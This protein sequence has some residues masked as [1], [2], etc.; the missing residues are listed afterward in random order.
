MPADPAAVERHYTRGG[1]VDTIRAA[2][3]QAGKDLDRL[4]VE[5]LAPLDHFHGRG[6]VATEQLAA[7]LK[8]TAVERVID[9]G[10]G[11][12]G[13]SRWLA[14]RFG[15]T[16]AGVDLTQEFVQVATMLTALTGL[17]ERVSYRQGT[18]LALPFPDASF[19][20]AW[21]QNASMNIADRAT[22]Y[23]EM[24]RVLKP[25]GRL[26]LQEVLQGPGGPPHFPSPWASEAGLSF[27]L[28]ETETRAALE[29]AGF[30]VLDWVDTT[31]AGGSSAATR[32]APAE[33]P[34]L[35]VH[36]LVGA[37]WREIYGNGTRNYREGRVRSMS[38][39]LRRG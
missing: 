6:L 30:A 10:S 11:I 8:P 16:V 7:Q 20:L 15:C 18:A 1:L 29:A 25:G 39:V 9:I 24:H 38:A 33:P 34:L 2:L 35:G 26:G 21:S 31:D 13:P 28:T 3:Q 23:R 22:L 37:R 4:T 19:D 5:D 32:A 12:G 27:L 14:R 17:A 36:L